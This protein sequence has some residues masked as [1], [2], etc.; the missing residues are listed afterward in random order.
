MQNYL[1]KILQISTPYLL[2][3]FSQKRFDEFLDVI[4]PI[5]K[6]QTR[7]DVI[8]SFSEKYIQF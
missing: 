5:K 3:T 2:K 4:S 8:K 7:E 1:D 6:I